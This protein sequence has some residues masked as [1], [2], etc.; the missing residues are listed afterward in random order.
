MGIISTVQISS[1]I[2]F[3]GDY[4]PST[5]LFSSSGCIPI[6]NNIPVAGQHTQLSRMEHV[7]LS[8]RGMHP[9]VERGPP[10]PLRVQ[11]APTPPILKGEKRGD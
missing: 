11:I 5:T 1:S 9:M 6:T 8:R 4:E 7:F 10:D 3:I 2:F